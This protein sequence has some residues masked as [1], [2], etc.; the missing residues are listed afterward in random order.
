MIAG[1]IGVVL[2]AGGP[3]MRVDL[4]NLRE[5]NRKLGT[6]SDGVR[7]QIPHGSGY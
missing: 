3:Q 7:G 1:L 5:V 2:G 4:P 6:L